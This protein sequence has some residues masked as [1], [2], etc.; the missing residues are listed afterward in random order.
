MLVGLENE[1]FWFFSVKYL[2]RQ[3]H[4]TS[5]SLFLLLDRV[6]FWDIEE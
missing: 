5:W 4:T 6:G 3:S 2:W 1:G